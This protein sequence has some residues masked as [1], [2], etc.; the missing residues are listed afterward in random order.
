M[1]RYTRQEETALLTIATIC[2]TK[3]NSTRRRK[4]RKFYIA[5]EHFDRMTAGAFA[6]VVPNL[7]DI[8]APRHYQYF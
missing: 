6:T 1:V 2:D 7:R 3:A 8:D 5:L 4:N